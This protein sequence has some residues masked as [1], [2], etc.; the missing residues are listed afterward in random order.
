MAWLHNLFNFL[1]LSLLRLFA[2]LPYSFT[3]HVGYGL[4]WLAAHIPNDR[5][6]VVKTNLR[7]CFP[8]LS[9]PEID[10]LALEHWKL[11]GRSVIERSRVWLGTSNQI[12]SFVHLESAVP[13]GDRKPR[14]LVNPHFVGLEGGFMALSALG[15]KN[16]WP[17]GAGLYQKMKNPF[18]NQKMVEW[19]D[20]FGAMSIERQSRLRDLIRET[21]AGN[22]VVIAPDIDLGP[23]DSI[24]APFFGIP[25]STVTSVSRLAKLSGAE[26]CLM[27]TL[28]NPKKT[29]YICTISRPL[30]DFPSDD[31]DKDTARLNLWIEE[32][33]RQ[34]PAEYYWVH[35]RFKHRPPGEPSLYK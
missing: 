28:L 27:T 34:R 35:K 20:R 5:A 17:R 21:R 2:F 6:Q 9:E 33:V 23:R 8:N 18:F 30:P 14:I 11:F 3:V 10:A 25:T 15:M 22:F 4:G 12:L 29:G 24:F 31:P 16:D 19:R 7:L 1:A 26:V 13:L 32:L